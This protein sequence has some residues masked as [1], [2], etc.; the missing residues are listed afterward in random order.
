M[1]NQK[2]QLKVVQGEFG[3]RDKGELVQIQPLADPPKQY[4]AIGKPPERVER[5]PT[6]IWIDP[7]F[8]R[9]ISHRGKT[10][11]ADMTREWHW[12]SFI[13]PAI[14]KDERRGL[15]VAYD[16]QHTLI[17]AASRNDILKIPCDLHETL[18]DAVAAAAAFLERNTHR[19]GVSPFQRFKAALKAEHQWATDLNAMAL[20]IG[21]RIPFYPSVK[22]RPDTVLSITTL[23][24]IIERRGKDGL[25]RI[26]RVLIGNGIAPIREMHLSALEVLLFDRDFAKLVTDGKLKQTIRGLNNNIMLGEATTEAIKRGMTRG[27]ALAMVYLREYQGVHGVR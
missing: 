23:Q 7:D 19:I 25:A 14:Y 5:E 4:D 11:I 12:P 24:D 10:L 13:P 3:P 1:K 18:E 15:E 21:F 17:G 22:V 2:P 8:Q 27:R 20:R 9:N 6:S 16:G 26:M